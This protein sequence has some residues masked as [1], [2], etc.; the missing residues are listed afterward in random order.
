M[1]INDYVTQSSSTWGL[2]RISHH[3]RTA[4]GYIYDETA[5]AGTCSYIIDTGI[6]TAHT[7]RYP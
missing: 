3:S 5:G 2:S 6:Y 4:T 7:V 1:S